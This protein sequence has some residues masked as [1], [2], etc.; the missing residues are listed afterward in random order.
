MNKLKLLF[1]FF[2]NIS[3]S[4]TD[5][6]VKLAKD[7]IKKNN[8]SNDQ[9]KIEGQK[10]GVSDIQLN[11]FLSNKN[12]PEVQKNGNDVSNQDQK[13]LDVI[14]FELESNNTLE[15]EKVVKPNSDIRIQEKQMKFFGYDIFMRD[16]ALFQGSSA[17]MLDP[18]YIIGPGDEIILMLWGETQFRQVLKVDIGG[19]IFIPE[20]GQVFVIGLDLK[21]LESKLF[22]V[23]SQSYES[24]NPQNRNP[25][26][27]LDISIGNLRPLRIQVLGEVN[28]PGAYTINPSA[29]LFSALYYFNGPTKLGSLRDIRLIR[30]GNQIASID[31]YEFLLKGKKP[32]DQKLQLDDII[33]IPP[34]L[35]TVTIKGEVKRPGTYEL[36]KN[37]SI[38]DIIEMSGG[39]KVTA[40]L[41]RIQI[42]RITPFG[43]REKSGMDRE[44]K[45][46]DLN[47][48][49]EKKSRYQ[50]LDG[51]KI[52][53]S[54]IFDARQNYVEIEG[55]VS[56]PGSYDIG[57]SL[58]LKQLIIKADS[59]TI[60]AYSKRAD[61]IRSNK[62]KD[63]LI[64]I[65]LSK[66]LN[67]NPQHNLSL[68]GLDKIKI[69][70]LNEII[71][72][73]F[74]SIIGDLKNP[75]PYP[76]QENMK[77]A[78]LIFISG[79]LV[80]EKQKRKI[81]LERADLIRRID[82]SNNYK[83]ISFNLEEVLQN[84]DSPLNLVLEAEDK[85]MIYSNSIFKREHFVRIKGS[86]KNPGK[87]KHKIKMTVKD[88]LLESKGVLDNVYHF[89]IDISRINPSINKQK[90]LAVLYTYYLKKID[91]GFEI[92]GDETL[93]S[94]DDI[95][96]EPYDLIHVRESPYFKLQE[97]IQ[98]NGS[99]NFPGEYVLN[100][101]NEK[102]VDI[103][104]LSGGLT[105]NAFLAGGSFERN[106]TK[107]QIDFLKAVEKPNSIYNIKIRAN[108]KIKIPERSN[109]FIIEGEVQVPGQYQ[110]EKNI[111]ISD[112]INNA[113][114]FT[115]DANIADIF[116]IKT[117][118]K[119]KKYSKYLK[120]HKVQENSIILVGKKPEEE[121]FDKTEYAKE[122]TAIIANLTQTLSILYLAFTN[123]N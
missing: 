111:K 65:D 89:R 69:Y 54:S 106:N 14:E 37:E 53:I 9:I 44:F 97:V 63:E 16:P 17:G 26:T 22:R 36:K 77:I 76:L 58:N 8:I 110:Y 7:Y 94:P 42:D 75:G 13:N 15:L 101:T 103:I 35:I 108:D 70:D 25:T 98:I 18:E 91:K 83:T 105:E 102:L 47:Q 49:L 52:K 122:L 28:Q 1:F 92:I 31:F 85:L 34:R 43:M 4:Q 74:V 24:L 93:L 64:Q 86:I 113:G 71:K 107:I 33:F 120:N 62:F 55:A 66:A 57:D 104:E 80:D 73:S 60:N 38:L 30:G 40:Y 10:R 46:L 100:S 118:G 119:S 50:L 29:T 72:K 45:D 79:S 3:L 51:D 48:I 116:M 12:Q 87:Y 61:I 11:K 27:F 96:L 68:I 123:S 23:L 20:V 88:L 81:F 109:N 32:L 117:N 99:V 78:D 112:A 39:L 2:L 5:T 82:N 56:R 84:K 115:V 19:F 114:G 121:P 6:Q 90:N 21:L 41:D 95:L 67:G 59:L